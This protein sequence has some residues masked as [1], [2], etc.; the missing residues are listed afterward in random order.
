VYKFGSDQSAQWSRAVLE[1]RGR[2]A[3]G[4][5]VTNKSREP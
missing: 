4:E 2:G 5:F 1:L 3:F